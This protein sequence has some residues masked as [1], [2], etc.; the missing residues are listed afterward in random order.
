MRAPS[1]YIYMHLSQIA[2]WQASKQ[3][4]YEAGSCEVGGGGED[5]EV[6]TLLLG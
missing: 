3:A 6:N 5:R 4:S 2:M 1:V